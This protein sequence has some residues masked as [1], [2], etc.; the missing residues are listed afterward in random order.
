MSAI[1]VI[2]KYIV[3]QIT[4]E[5]GNVIQEACEIPGF[6]VISTKQLVGLDEFIS[7]EEA[8]VKFAG[9]DT[10]LYVFA[11]ETEAKEKL[12]FTDDEGYKPEFENVLIVPEKVTIRQAKLALLQTGL[13]DQVIQAIDLIEDPMQKQAF[14]IEW[15]YAQEIERHSPTLLAVTDGLGMNEEQINELFILAN[16]L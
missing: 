5:E 16:S 9:T 6:L 4:D 15:E 12:N 7:P 1:S 10:L 11:D 13:Y 14:K 2:G 3:P 8:P